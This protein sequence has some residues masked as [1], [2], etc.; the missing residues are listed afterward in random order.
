M[1]IFEINHMSCRAFMK[2]SI[3][4]ERCHSTTSTS[5][6]MIYSPSAST[7]YNF[8]RASTHTCGTRDRL[9]PCDENND[10]SFLKNVLHIEKTSLF[11]SSCLS[12]AQAQ[13]SQPRLAVGATDSRLHRCAKLLLSAPANFEGHGASE[14]FSAPFTS[15]NFILLFHVY[16]DENVEMASIRIH[17]GLVIAYAGCAI[18]R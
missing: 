6:R 18:L 17:P 2:T 7:N 1:P 13:P 9:E 15:A 14:G 8:S 16:K 3:C 12:T 10:T 5:R 4:R 11:A